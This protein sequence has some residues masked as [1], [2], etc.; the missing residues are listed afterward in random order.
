V[1]SPSWGGPGAFPDRYAAGKQQIE[2]AF[3]I[4]IVEMPH[5][6]A[7]PEWVAANPAARAEDMMQAFADPSIAGIVASIGGEDAIRLIA[8]LDLDIIAANPKVF[9]GFSD[10][11]SLHFACQRAGLT[12]F[13]GPSIMAGFGENTGM[14]R[15]TQDGV[16]QALFETAPIGAIAANTEG[17]TAER[18][19]WGDPAL[20]SR[21]RRMQPAHP[22]RILQGRDSASGHLIGGCAEVLEMLKGT[23]W[24]PPLDYWSGA[25]LFYETSEEAPAPDLV[26]RWLRNFAAQG[27]LEVL[28]GIVLARPDPKG[29]ESYRQRLEAAILTALAECGLEHL[30][31]LSGL[32]FGHTQP[33]LT[34]PFGVEAR[35][36]CLTATMTIVEPGVC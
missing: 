12:S 24:W 8:H 31:V 7:S 32:D 3:G 23:A 19:N 6:L 15:Y 4:E 18:L 20:Q 17:W 9:L 26:R 34:L 13:Y 10:T 14:H 28:S 21:P 29:D 30:P 22:P 36:D 33:M 1:V 5:A 25:I 35:I 2:A 16:R 11:T 27:I